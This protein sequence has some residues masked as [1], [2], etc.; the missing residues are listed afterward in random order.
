[1]KLYIVE[2]PTKIQFCGSQAECSAARAELGRQGVARKDIE[3]HE[4]D[5]P[6]VKGELLGFLNHLLATPDVHDNVKVVT[7][8]YALTRRG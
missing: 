7:G 3:T 4:V 1:M 6:T 2:S 8:H 5:V